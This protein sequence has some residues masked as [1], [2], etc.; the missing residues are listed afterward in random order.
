MSQL[1]CLHFLNALQQVFERA[2][3][4]ERH[5]ADLAVTSGVEVERGRMLL[6]TKKTRLNTCRSSFSQA[7]GG[8]LC[9]K[10]TGTQSTRLLS[11]Y[12]DGKFMEVLSS[13][14]YSGM[15]LKGNASVLNMAQKQTLP[16]YFKYAWHTYTVFY[17]RLKKNK[18]SNIYICS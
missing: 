17:G 5:L 10:R 13:T 16:H 9:A 4:S 14:Q 2:P 11:P 7:F 3:A 15:H 18:T 12:S 1:V 6:G 8:L